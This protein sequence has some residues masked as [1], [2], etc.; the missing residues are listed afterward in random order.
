MRRPNK[1]E[2]VFIAV[3][4]AAGISV[5]MGAQ[6]KD[7]ADKGSAV[8]EVVAKAARKSADPAHALALAELDPAQLQ[9]PAPAAVPGDAFQKKSWYVPPPPPPPPV[10]APPPP[11]PPP[12]APPLPFTFMGRYVDGDKPVIFLT[13]GDRLLMVHQG[14]VIDGT[15]RVE[16]FFGTKLQIMYL[17]L[18]IKQALDIGSAG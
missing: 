17:P 6:Q 16:G 11:P 18:N 5:V 13:A 9:R 3:A 10:I 2:W 7:P 15:Y 1:R 12:T 4:L 8:V 14:D